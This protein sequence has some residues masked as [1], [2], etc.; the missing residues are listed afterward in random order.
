MLEIKKMTNVRY[1]QLS[2]AAFT[3][4]LIAYLLRKAIRGTTK[5]EPGPSAARTESDT[6]C[7]STSG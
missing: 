1:E 6:K 5:L 3:V 4:H 2:I 7:L